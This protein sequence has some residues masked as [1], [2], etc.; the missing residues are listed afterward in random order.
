M[1]D[2]LRRCNKQSAGS[3]MDGIRATTALNWERYIHNKSSIDLVEPERWHWRLELFPHDCLTLRLCKLNSLV[4]SNERLEAAGKLPEVTS[5]FDDMT[6]NA[7][8][9]KSS[10]RT[11]GTVGEG[12]QSHAWPSLSAG[13]NA[14]LLKGSYCILQSP[15]AHMG[16]QQML[17]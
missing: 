5:C 6:R 2:I 15:A 9:H 14:P 1:G 3:G 8:M 17:G 11:T 12:L 16:P 10:G 7:S 4:E 13:Q